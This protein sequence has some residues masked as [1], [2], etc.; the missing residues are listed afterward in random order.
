[1]KILFVTNNEKSKK[2]YQ[3]LKEREESVQLLETPID[4]EIVKKHDPEMIVSY[5]YKYMIKKDVIQYLKGNIINLHI[6]LLPWNRGLS[7]NLWSFID[8]T[9]KGVSIHY[10]DEG[11]DTGNIIVQKELKFSKKEET[12]ATTYERLNEEVQKLFFEYWNQIKRNQITAVP[13]SGKGSYHGK[14]D[15][16]DLQKKIEFSWDDNIEAFLEKYKCCMSEG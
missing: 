13:Q 8:H 1:M 5:N 16:S 14:K 6:S 3:W 7:P 11:I 15:I 2:L 4:L 9:P 10:V 12:F